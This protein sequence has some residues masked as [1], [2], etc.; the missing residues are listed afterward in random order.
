MAAT[1][2]RKP[3]AKPATKPAAK[4]TTKAP[5]K[6][7]AKTPSKAEPKPKEQKKPDFTVEELR[8]TGKKFAETMR[9]S[10]NEFKAYATGKVETVE[11]DTK[12][13]RDHITMAKF[14]LRRAERI[15]LSLDELE[16]EPKE[17]SP[18]GTRKAAEVVDT[19]DEADDEDEDEDEDEDSE[20]V[21]DDET[22][23]D[24]EDD[25]LDDDDDDED[26]DLD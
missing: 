14:L 23:D 25:S 26:D 21:V 11:A 18:R 13:Y 6:A 3:A 17:R 2:T 16:A 24:D 4:A 15:E 1:T 5:A 19:A 20:T 12:V 22:E 8:E 10:L 9:L 7:A